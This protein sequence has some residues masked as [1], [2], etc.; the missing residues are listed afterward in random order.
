MI[1]SGLV[2]QYLILAF[3]ILP[4]EDGSFSL[5]EED[6]ILSVMAMGVS[7]M[8]IYSFYGKRSGEGG[9]VGLAYFGIFAAGIFALFALFLAPVALSGREFVWPTDQGEQVTLATTLVVTLLGLWLSVKRAVDAV[10]PALSVVGYPVGP[11][12]P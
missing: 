11:S 2:L 9:S 12:L 6:T 4:S 1:V 7:L 5:G 10:G 3:N 8:G